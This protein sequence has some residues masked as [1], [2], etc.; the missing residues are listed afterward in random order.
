MTDN[1]I[2]TIAPVVERQAPETIPAPE[3][4]ALDKDVTL[5]QSRLNEILKDA[6]SRAAKE[7]RQRVIELETEN[8]N[9]KAIAARSGAN[10]SELEK[11]RAETAALKM[12]NDA[13][14]ATSQRQASLLNS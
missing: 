12:E 11:A 3:I 10:S 8:A 5:K 7:L 14:R 9:H 6:Q 13:I 2:D 4:A 1:L